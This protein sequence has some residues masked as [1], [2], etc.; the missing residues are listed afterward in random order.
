MAG[1]SPESNLILYS[2]I[3]YL[4]V[5]SENHGCLSSACL[6]DKDLVPKSCI[7]KNCLEFPGKYTAPPWAMS[8]TLAATPLNSAWRWVPSVPKPSS[9]YREA[10]QETSGKIIFLSFIN[11]PWP[12]P[13]II[14]ARKFL[15]QTVNYHL[16]C[17]TS[18]GSG[19]DLEALRELWGHM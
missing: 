1:N 19:W 6:E 3:N 8:L 16:G 15:Q 18:Q 10:S 13:Q 11:A 7:V 4:S 9:Q 5:N 17:L 2:A 14:R 12:C